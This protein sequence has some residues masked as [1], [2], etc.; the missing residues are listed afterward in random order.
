MAQSIDSFSDF[1][2][3]GDVSKDLLDPVRK[4][5]HTLMK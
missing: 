4:G 2:P 5:T 1:M 3:T